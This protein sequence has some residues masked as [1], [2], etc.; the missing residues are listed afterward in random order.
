MQ[1]TALNGT[2]GLEFISVH[3]CINPV[4]KTKY[5]YMHVSKTLGNC[6]DKPERVF[7]SL[8]TV[9]LLVYRRLHTPALPGLFRTMCTH[10]TRTGRKDTWSP[11]YSIYMHRCMYSTQ[12][13]DK[14]RFPQLCIKCG[15]AK[16]CPGTPTQLCRH[17]WVCM[18]LVRVFLNT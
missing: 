1:H 6:G 9:I 17:L 2:N 14:I 16:S 10:I 13:S 8:P 7:S 4:D 5:D 12:C 11:A 15:V 3:M 18:D